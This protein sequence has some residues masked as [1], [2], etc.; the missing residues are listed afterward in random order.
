[1]AGTFDD[2]D[3][4]QMDVI[5]E[6]GNIGAGNAAT[7]L[8][9]ILGRMV[10]MSVPEVRIIPLSSAPEILGAPDQPVVGGLVDMNGG[11]TGQILLVLGIRE[12]Y[13]LASILYGRETY[14]ISGVD[15]S[16]F[17]ELEI[18]A[19][20]E[21]TNILSGSYLSAISALSGLTISP[22]VPYMCIDMAGAILSLIAVEYGKTGDSA[23][24][25]ETRFIDAEDDLACHF[26]L[27]PDKES[28][29]KL[30]LS[31]GVS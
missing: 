12:A 10:G 31:L 20:Y 18:S 26:F 8:S 21:V 24:F 28:Y 17:T 27:L 2:I 15:V 1:M 14:G 6:I 11:L 19:L 7:A 29:K 30:M 3:P 25:F 13:V 5:R 9:G 4:Q 23:L 22:S 16:A